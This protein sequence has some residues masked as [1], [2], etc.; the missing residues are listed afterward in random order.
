MEGMKVTVQG[1]GGGVR[2]Q[3]ASVEGQ[4]SFSCHCKKWSVAWQGHWF[5]N[6]FW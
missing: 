6:S 1:G 5:W 2:E 3:C 4:E